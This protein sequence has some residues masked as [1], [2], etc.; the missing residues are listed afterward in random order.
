[1]RK[2]KSCVSCE[3]SA[4]SP[5]SHVA[6]SHLFQGLVLRDREEPFPQVLPDFHGLTVGVFSLIQLGSEFVPRLAGQRDHVLGP[7]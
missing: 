5:E 3:L 6:G 1:M 4:H 2:E 7:S